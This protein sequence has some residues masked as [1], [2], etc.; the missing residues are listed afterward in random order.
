MAYV[1]VV[2]NRDTAHKPI[3]TLRNH[4]KWIPSPR[5]DKGGAPLDRAVGNRLLE[6]IRAGG[7]ND[8]GGRMVAAM[9]VRESSHDQ[10]IT[11]CLRF[12]NLYVVA[13]GDG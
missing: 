9:T 4:D 7:A 3:H 5:G 11:T 13:I 6:E 2:Q 10:S 1:P 12:P 8:E